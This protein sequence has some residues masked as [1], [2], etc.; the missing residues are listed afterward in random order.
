MGLLFCFI[1]LSLILRSNEFDVTMGNIRVA[2]LLHIKDGDIFLW[3]AIWQ[4]P[5]DVGLMGILGKRL[6]VLILPY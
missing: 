4:Q 1:S 5:K 6:T 2:V 3:P